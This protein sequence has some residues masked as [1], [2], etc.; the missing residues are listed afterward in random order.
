MHTVC[1]SVS[2]DCRHLAACVHSLCCSV[3]HCVAVC[4][5]ASQCVAVCCSVLQCVAVYDNVLQCVASHFMCALSVSTMDSAENDTPPR[6][7]KSK[8]SDTSVQIEIGPRF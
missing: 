5:T 2:R 1:V 4:C 8:D 3:L 6:S 7:T